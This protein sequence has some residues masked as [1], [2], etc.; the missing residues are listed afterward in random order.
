MISHDR[1]STVIRGGRLIKWKGR[2]ASLSPT[3]MTSAAALTVM[4]LG[5]FV[6][7]TGAVAG[8]C[9][10]PTGINFICSG[11]GGGLG[12]DTPV[13]LNITVGGPPVTDSTVGFQ[14]DFGV[15]TGLGDAVSIDVQG[16]GK[17]N[18]NITDQAPSG[19][20]LAVIIVTG[21][22]AGLVIDN[23]T[24]GTNTLVLERDISTGGSGLIFTN[25]ENAGD[26]SFA[27]N[28]AIGATTG[29]VDRDAVN[30]TQSGTGKLI[31][32]TGADSSI[33]LY[34]RQ[35]AAIDF[36]AE[37]DSA[38]AEI[39]LGGSIDNNHFGGVGVVGRVSGGSL[40]LETTA[41]STINSGY[42]GI[43][44]TT[45]LNAEDMT[46]SHNGSVAVTG[47]DTGIYLS[48][49]GSGNLVMTTG[50]DSSVTTD[51]QGAIDIRT[52]A[53]SGSL[54][55]THNGQV[56]SG[57]G[58]GLYI[59]HAGSGALTL[60][61]SAGSSITGINNGVR[62]SNSEDSGQ[63]NLSFAGDVTAGQMN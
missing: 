60:T 20:P 6:G 8:S 31:L 12:N 23:D 57:D 27:L 48:H 52:K 63:M 47:N 15:N 32:T 2:A 56:Y 1:K 30:L 9:S 35:K 58:T 26:A 29:T 54:S 36:T 22:H 16:S 53:G 61:N 21:D 14:S 38:G 11:P 7:P 18:L 19:D 50:A 37:E 44:L 59:S 39:T 5:I 49:G 40:S 28:G 25:V 13:N 51:D 46:V 55:V 62:I 3:L 41:G 17:I 34:D 24:G 45:D 33:T 4:S 42:G 43:M 10:P